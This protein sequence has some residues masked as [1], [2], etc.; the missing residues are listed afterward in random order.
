MRCSLER[1]HRDDVQSL[2]Q[3]R[4]ERRREA[5]PYTVLRH[6]A[7]PR[8]STEF[9]PDVKEVVAMW[10]GTTWAS[11]DHQRMTFIH[12]EELDDGHPYPH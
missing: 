1:R 8:E 3:W 2:D 12:G 11:H 5:L 10:D 7:S 9:P 4:Q 6:W